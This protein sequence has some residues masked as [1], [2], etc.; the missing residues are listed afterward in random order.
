MHTGDRTCGTVGGQRKDQR[1]RHDANETN[2]KCFHLYKSVFIRDEHSTE[3]I[4]RNKRSNR[5]DL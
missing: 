1:E 3:E 5:L 4:I 2:V